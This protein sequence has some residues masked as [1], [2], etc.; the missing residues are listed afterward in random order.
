MKTCNLRTWVQA[1]SH[2]LELALGKL[3]QGYNCLVHEKLDTYLLFQATLLA[4]QCREEEAWS[5][6]KKTFQKG[7]EEIVQ[8]SIALGLFSSLD[9]HG[10]SVSNKIDIMNG[11]NFDTSL[12]DKKPLPC[13]DIFFY[14]LL[15][16][17]ILLPKEMQAAL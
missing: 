13:L 15:V 4:I 6:S 12:P 3:C 7:I 14:L 10:T 11:H 8:H 16:A 2:A 9:A 17:C 1:G 5:T